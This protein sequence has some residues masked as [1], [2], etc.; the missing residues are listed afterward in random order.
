MYPLLLQPNVLSPSGVQRGEESG[1]GGRPWLKC[2]QKLKHRLVCKQTRIP[3]NV[4]SNNKLEYKAKQD[5]F[6][7][8]LKDSHKM[9]MLIKDM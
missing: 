2:F 5:R 9:Q 6:I 3:K 4:S 8:F 7:V 1:G